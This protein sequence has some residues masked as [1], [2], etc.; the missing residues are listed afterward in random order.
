MLSAKGAA[1]LVAM[2][3]TS[4]SAGS[5]V[6][7]RADISDVTSIMS[8]SSTTEIQGFEGHVRLAASVE[9]FVDELPP[10][11]VWRQAEDEI[12]I[13]LAI[14][15]A[16]ERIRRSGGCRDPRRNCAQFCIGSSFWS[17]LKRWEAAGDGRHASTTLDSCARLVARMPKY[18]PNELLKRT[19]S[20]AGKEPVLRNADKAKAWRTHITKE[21]EA[22]RL[23]FW[24][25]SDDMIEL[26]NI[27]GK[28]ELEIL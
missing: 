8:P 26:A 7:V 20:R 10:H 2:F 14:R 9:N 4:D 13:A 11:V 19:A 24:K 1:E 5:E 27:G 18:A 15:L 21:H 28:F 17:S 22:M 6:A 16:A 23:M 3:S 25:R 12:G